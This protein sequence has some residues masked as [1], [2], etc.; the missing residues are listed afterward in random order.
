M[1][2]ERIGVPAVVTIL[3]VLALVALPP[4]D[5]LLKHTESRTVLSD[6]R[7][8]WQKASSSSEVGPEDVRLILEK[9]TRHREVLERGQVREVYEM[10][11]GLFPWGRSRKASIH[12][13]YSNLGRV[14]SVS[15]EVPGGAP[16]R[17]EQTS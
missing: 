9:Y 1:E 11:V 15:L 12:V 4:L 13:L 2:L 10:H 7:K 5:A 6:Y 3:A 14:V 16:A 17:R 8:V